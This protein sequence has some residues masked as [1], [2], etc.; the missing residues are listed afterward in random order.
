MYKRIATIVTLATI[1]S[2]N[3]IAQTSWGKTEHR[4]EPWVTNA[5]LPYSIERGLQGRH[6]S[7]W[8]SHGQYFDQGKHQWR[9]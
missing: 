1:V 5:S 3:A 6:L 4:G 2:I 7:L 8:A 9:W